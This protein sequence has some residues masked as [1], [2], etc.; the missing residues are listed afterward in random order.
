MKP[1]VIVAYNSRICI[2][3]IFKGGDAVTSSQLTESWFQFYPSLSKL[4]EDHCRSNARTYSQCPQNIRYIPV[5]LS[6]RRTLT[7]RFSIYF[8]RKRKRFLSY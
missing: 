4:K 5:E 2:K 1:D 8:I 7:S 3:P 6:L